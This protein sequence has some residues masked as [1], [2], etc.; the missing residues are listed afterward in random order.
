MRL[1]R[2]SKLKDP[3]ASRQRG[4]LH[5]RHLLQQGVPIIIGVGQPSQVS[6]AID[7]SMIPPTLYISYVYQINKG[8]CEALLSDLV[9][10]LLI[11]KKIAVDSVELDQQ[12]LRGGNAQLDFDLHAFLELFLFDF[13]AVGIH[14]S[15]LHKERSTLSLPLSMIWENFRMS[16]SSPISSSSSSSLSL[17]SWFSKKLF[18]RET[19]RAGS[20]FLRMSSFEVISRVGSSL[21][22]WYSLL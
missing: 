17:I 7:P 16:V 14:H 19:E 4:R 9:D 20:Y 21:L 13:V 8:S 6:R 2:Q 11:V 12:F 10:D 15:D 3:A 22:T 18:R 5:L 1:L